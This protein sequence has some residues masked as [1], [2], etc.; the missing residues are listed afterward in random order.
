L[1]AA[2]ATTALCAVPSVAGLRALTVRLPGAA[3]GEA[4]SRP[5]GRSGNFLTPRQPHQLT[6]S[7]SRALYVI[8][9]GRDQ[10][11]GYD[12][13]GRFQVVAGDGRHGF[14][15]DGGPA[16]DAEL[17]LGP[18]AQS[19]IAVSRS[20]TVY[21]S[22]NGRVRAVL[23]G[24]MIET[25]AGGGR[26]PLPG[27]PG[28]LVPARSASLGG[29]T[30][31]ALGPGGELYMAAGYIV[32]LT[33]GGDLAYVAGSGPEAKNCGCTTKIVEPDFSGVDQLAFDGSGDLVASSSGFPGEA[34]GLAEV[35]ADGRLLNLGNVRA[36]AG[37]PTALAPG[38]NGSVF[39]AAAQG[40]YEIPNGATALR[41]VPGT[42]TS[43]GSVLSAALGPFA[44]SHLMQT[45]V[46]GDGIAVAA[47][48]DIYVDENTGS[49]T[50]G[51][52]A[53][54]E[55][56]PASKNAHAIWRS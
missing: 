14:S 37:E 52:G 31:L 50:S 20:R 10:V 23:P 7:P 29:V 36:G 30:G 56:N 12:V 53:I 15:G 46:P 39:V 33:P 3:V 17:D 49:P 45:F 32:R 44:H 9:E 18:G 47:S 41:P 21:F 43:R 4:A 27:R 26:R 51:V 16:V 11:L 34:F 1:A 40:L 42:A 48:G 38:P 6:V 5:A 13:A 8:D 35:R 55:F 54:V 25:V 24:G 2:A 19:G 22:D 28:E